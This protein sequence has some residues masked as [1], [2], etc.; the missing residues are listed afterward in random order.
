FRGT[1]ISLAA[2]GSV[3]VERRA[4]DGAVG[5]AC[6]RSKG[7]LADEEYKEGFTAELAIL[8]LFEVTPSTS[9]TL[10]QHHGLWSMKIVNGQL[11]VVVYSPSGIQFPISVPGT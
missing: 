6:K 5:S 11:Q 2:N 1:G 9:M 3:V 8:P 4:A 7:C 10:A